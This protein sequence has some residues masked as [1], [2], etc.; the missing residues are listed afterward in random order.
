MLY[1]RLSQFLPT[2]RAAVAALETFSG[3]GGLVAKRRHRDTA[4]GTPIF[5]VL[6]PAGRR[7]DS[8]I[9]Q[10]RLQ[11]PHTEWTLVDMDA[12]GFETPC[13]PETP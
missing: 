4:G 5:V 6:V 10:L 9:K 1:L 12:D 7:P 3:H 8:L 11:A 2:D 13:S